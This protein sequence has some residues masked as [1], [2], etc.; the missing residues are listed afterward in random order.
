MGCLREPCVKNECVPSLLDGVSI[1]VDSLTYVTRLSKSV[2]LG[3]HHIRRY[4]PI[5]RGTDTPG[6]LT[7]T[8][9]LS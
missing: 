6:H 2:Y 7:G 5:T 9:K 3:P 1:D 8:C 4:E